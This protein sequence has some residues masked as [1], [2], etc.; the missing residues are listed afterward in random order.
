MNLRR[1]LAFPLARY[2]TIFRLYL[3]ITRFIQNPEKT[4][5]CLSGKIT[6]HTTTRLPRQNWKI[7]LKYMSRWKEYI[8]KW[9]FRLYINTDPISWRF[10]LVIPL[11]HIIFTEPFIAD[12]EC[13]CA[14]WADKSRNDFIQNG[15]KILSMC[16]L[17]IEYANTYGTCGICGAAMR[18]RQELPAFIFVWKCMRG[19]IEIWYWS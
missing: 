7:C 1:S 14:F 9:Y 3:P 17:K 15:Q 13:L 4:A 19:N 16:T 10:N 6:N 8:R 12:G 5:G 18:T 11:K 2:N